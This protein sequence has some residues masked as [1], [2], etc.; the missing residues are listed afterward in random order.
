MGSFAADARAQHRAVRARH[1]TN[2]EPRAKK[3]QYCS[4]SCPS[5]A[6]TLP[7]PC[8]TGGCHPR[9]TSSSTRAKSPAP[10]LPGLIPAGQ[11]SR[12]GGGHQYLATRLSSHLIGPLSS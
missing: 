3:H 11:K 10:F 4:R 5:F 9:P 1:C 2:T 6:F 8:A 7:C 12:N